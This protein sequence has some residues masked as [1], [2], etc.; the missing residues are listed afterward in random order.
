MINKNK[1]LTKKLKYIENDV[2]N[3]EELLRIQYEKIHKKPEWAKNIESVDEES[4]PI[5][6]ICV[7]KFIIL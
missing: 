4:L 7:F 1:K 2:D 3:D 6:G 5:I